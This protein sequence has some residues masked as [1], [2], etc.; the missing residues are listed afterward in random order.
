MQNNENQLE[1]SIYPINPNKVETFENPNFLNDWE[2]DRLVPDGYE[3]IDSPNREGEKALRL[4]VKR[5]DFARPKNNPTRERCELGELEKDFVNGE[6]KVSYELSFLIPDDFYI[7][8]NRLVIM[9][10][11]TNQ[12][13]NKEN[14]PIALRYMNGDLF[15]TIKKNDEWIELFRIKE[16]DFKKGEWHDIK[17]EYEQNVDHKGSIDVCFDGNEIGSYKGSFGYDYL[18][19]DMH[20]RFGLYRDRFPDNESDHP[21]TILFSRFKRTVV[22]KE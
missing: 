4:K 6:S 14:P 20:F 16:V 2:T 7:T 8:D 15:L 12:T 21:Q 10:L 17:I 18:P 5:G 11:R 1:K 3:I 9:Q 19:I 22:S 13:P